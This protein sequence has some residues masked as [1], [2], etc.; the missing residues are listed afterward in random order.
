MDKMSSF[1]STDVDV[2]VVIFVDAQ[3]DEWRTVVLPPPGRTA[4]HF[5]ALSQFGSIFVDRCLESTARRFF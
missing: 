4:E 2:D 1:C 5:L 3:K